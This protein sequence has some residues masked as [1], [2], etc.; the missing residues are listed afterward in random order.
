[1]KYATVADYE[2]NTAAYD[3]ELSLW[4]VLCR[5]YG[6]ACARALLRFN[7]AYYE[8][9]DVCLR[10]AS[11]GANPDDIKRG[12]KFLVSMED[13][14]A[15]LSAAPPGSRRLVI[16]LKDYHRTQKKWFEK[17]SQADDR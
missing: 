4:K 14:L 17:L 7:D 9:Y 2:W 12:R 1:M 10:M 6:P 3:P 15:I 16:E 5:L 8:V 11:A 13:Q